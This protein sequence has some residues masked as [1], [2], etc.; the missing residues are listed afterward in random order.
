M[1]IWDICKKKNLEKKYKLLYDNTTWTVLYTDVFDSSVTLKD[2][3]NNDIKIMYGLSELLDFDFEEVVD[4][5]KVAVDTK[6]LVANFTGN[7]N[8]IVWKKRYFAKYEN[9]KIYAWDSGFTSFTID[10]DDLCTSWD[11]VKLYE[12]EN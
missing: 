6:I 1:K 3:N 11:F 2:V 4:W 12:E 9:G 5:S 8:K 7:D 10:S